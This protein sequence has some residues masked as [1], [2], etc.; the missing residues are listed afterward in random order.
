MNVSKPIVI[1][2][3]KKLTGDKAHELAHELAKVSDS[4]TDSCE[5]I[6][7]I[8]PKDIISFSK[9]KRYKIV[10]QDIF[11]S[12]DGDLEYYFSDKNIDHKNVYGILLNH[13]EKKMNNALLDR[14]VM[15]S[16]KFGLR[17]LLCSSS[18]DEAT[19]LSK[20]N[21]SFIGIESESLIGKSGSFL[22]HCPEIVKDAKNKVN[23][24]ILIGAGIKDKHDFKHV[25]NDGGSGVLISSIILNSND[26]KNALEAFIS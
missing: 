18:I 23:N 12:I 10:V 8:Q 21:P 24:K 2:N 14:Y 13:P 20:Y 16:N 19:V 5:I 25:L 17:I 22:N 4:I 9:F 7:A 1:I 26:P 6:L 15:E 11:S 3:F